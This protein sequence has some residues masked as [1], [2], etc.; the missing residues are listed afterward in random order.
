MEHNRSSLI[1]PIMVFSIRPIEKGILGT[2]LRYDYEVRPEKDY[3]SGISTPKFDKQ[4]VQLAEH[5]LDTKA[6]HF[7][8]EKFKDRYE[9]ARKALVKRKATGKKIEPPEPRAKPSNVVN[10]MEALKQS[11][12]EGYPDC[13]IGVT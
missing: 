1:Q 3:F 8:P 6:A 13:R 10:L 4:M 11:R 12:R 7:D 5:I 2:T 9:T